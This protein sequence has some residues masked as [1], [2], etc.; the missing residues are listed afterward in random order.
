MLSPGRGLLRWN[1][2][3]QLYIIVI[4]ILEFLPEGEDEGDDEP[5]DD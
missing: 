3:N 5:E 2:N 4:V 1:L